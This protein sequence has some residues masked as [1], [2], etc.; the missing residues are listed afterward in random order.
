MRE[1]A[2]ALLE[3]LEQ[4]EFHV[5]HLEA[6]RLQD[7]EELEDTRIK[8]RQEIEELQEK[9]NQELRRSRERIHA[10]EDESQYQQAM[11]DVLNA[12]VERLEAETDLK[13]TEIEGYISQGVDDG[14]ARQQTLAFMRD[15]IVEMFDNANL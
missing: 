3:T 10:L 9:H 12:E 8:H 15:T 5:Q 7:R 1:H 14:M 2:F 6:D 4:L 11:L 13:R